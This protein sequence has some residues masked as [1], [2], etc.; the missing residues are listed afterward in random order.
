MNRR[1]GF[2]LCF[3]FADVLGCVPAQEGRVILAPEKQ[4][5]S[6]PLIP[7]DLL[8][9]RI[10]Y[11]NNTLAKDTLSE[12]DRQIATDLLTTYTSVK[13]AASGPLNETGY[14]QLTRDLLSALARMDAHYFSSAEMTWDHSKAVSH[15]M[16]KRREILDAHFSRDDR[17]VI[18]HCLEM[19][20]AFGPDALTPEIAALFALS[21]ANTGMREEA[22]NIIEGIVPELDESPDPNRLHAHIAALQLQLGQRGKARETYNKLTERLHRQERTLESLDKRMA[23]TATESQAPLETTSIQPQRDLPVKSESGETTEQLLQRADKL[24]AERKFGEAWD[25]LVLNRPVVMSN[26]ERLAV[27]KALER[28]EAAQEEYLEKTISMISKKKETLKTARRY[29]EEEKFEAALSNLEAFPEGE[30]GLEV[31]ELREQ[32]IEGLINRERNRAARIFLN[33]KRTQ[34]PVKKAA[35]LNDCYEILNSLLERYPSSPLSEK[36]RSHIRSVSEEMEKLK[37]HAS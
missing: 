36:I 4:V 8:N 27:D 22:M 10:D 28:L 2:I 14:R 21:L 31:K 20:A 13:N 17:G 34:D 37:E 5:V 26:A 6:G 7:E 11:L 30:A 19:Q 15:F 24:I 33:A 3:L 16:K 25:L 12:K 32:A 18:N 1:I 23:S 35:Y 9:K 29:L